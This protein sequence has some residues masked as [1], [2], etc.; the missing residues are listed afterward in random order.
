MLEELQIE[1]KHEGNEYFENGDGEKE[2]EVEEDEHHESG[3]YLEYVEPEV[4]AI[5]SQIDEV[6]VS[7]FGLVV[8]VSFILVLMK[9]IEHLFH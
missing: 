5:D 8:H 7:L 1:R 2:L 6:V 3:D 9:Y 4:A